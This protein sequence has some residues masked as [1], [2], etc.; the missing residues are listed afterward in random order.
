[1]QGGAIRRQHGAT[2]IRRHR[3]GPR[4]ENRMFLDGAPRRLRASVLAI[5]NRRQEVSPMN[6]VTTVGAPRSPRSRD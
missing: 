1:M 4:P 2:L 5:V 3:A 6:A